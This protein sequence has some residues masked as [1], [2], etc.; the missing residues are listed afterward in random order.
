MQV[1]IQSENKR[2]AFENGHTSF[3]M[4]PAFFG[5]DKEDTDEDG[6]V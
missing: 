1:M 2:L 4:D 6:M 3:C 5:L